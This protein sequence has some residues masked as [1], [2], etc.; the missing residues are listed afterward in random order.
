M[1]TRMPETVSAAHAQLVYLLAQYGPLTD[2]QLVRRLHTK[3][4]RVAAP[5]APQTDSGV[6]TRRR[7]LVVWSV[8]QSAAEG[9][10]SAGGRR[11]QRWELTPTQ[12][13]AIAQ[14]PGS[15]LER[16]LRALVDEADTD[17]TIR[18]CLVDLARA[19]GVVL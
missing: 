18:A 11:T 16:T 15:T 10:K 12:P 19:A 2:A 4:A 5:W 8:V 14:G 17:L 1:A 13:L 6:R 7:E 3:S 9:A